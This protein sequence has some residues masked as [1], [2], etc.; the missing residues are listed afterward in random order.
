MFHQAPLCNPTETIMTTGLALGLEQGGG[1]GGSQNHADTERIAND[2]IE[3]PTGT[4]E[5]N[6]TALE[7]DDSP[8]QLQLQIEDTDEE[9]NKIL[10]PRKLF[11]D[12]E[13]TDS[14]T[15]EP[16]DD[17]VFNITQRSDPNARK[18]K[19]RNAFR[20]K[21]RN[22]NSKGCKSLPRVPTV[23]RREERDVERRV[24]RSSLSLPTTPSQVILHEP[25]ILERVLPQHA[26]VVPEAVQMGP[27]VQHLD[28]A[29]EGIR[30]NDERPRR[31]SRRKIDYKKLN[32]TGDIS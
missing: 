13:T 2:N 23:A 25:Q 20:R 28:R 10:K 6:N 7:W 9:L 30:Q 1:Q 26:P 16:T 27:L 21:K 29:L 22:N 3:N 11:T 12:D 8:E 15:S 17:E 18:L 5:E 31:S 24:T 14:I 4:E 32:E 19:R